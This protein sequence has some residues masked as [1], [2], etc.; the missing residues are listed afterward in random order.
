[1]YYLSLKEVVLMKR[2]V[3]MGIIIIMLLS[4][5]AGITQ[6]QSASNKWGYK[7]NINLQK[8]FQPYVKILTDMMVKNYNQMNQSYQ[9]NYYDVELNG[10]VNMAG[11]MKKDG[12]NVLFDAGDSTNANLSFYFNGTFPYS[13]NVTNFINNNLEPK[14]MNISGKTAIVQTAISNGTAFTDGNGNVSKIISENR[15]FVKMH[16]KGKNLPIPA[17]LYAA[18]KHKYTRTDYVNISWRASFIST[19][20]TPTDLYFSVKLKE[21]I[22]NKEV[23]LI[24]IS[25]VSVEDKNLSVSVEDVNHDGLLDTGDI[26]GIHGNLS[27]M[28]ELMKNYKSIHLQIPFQYEGH[29]IYL[30]PSFFYS[31]GQWMSGSCDIYTILNTIEPHFRKI[32]N[33]F[34]NMS[35]YDNFDFTVEARYNRNTTMSFSPSLSFMPSKRHNLT[36]SVNGDYS[37]TVKIIGLQEKYLKILELLLNKTFTINGNVAEY[38]FSGNFSETK[39]AQAP[40]LHISGEMQYGGENVYV[41]QVINTN[42]T[43]NPSSNYNFH[44]Y[45][46]YSK[47]KRFI[48]GGGIDLGIKKFDTQPTSYEDAMNEIKSI[49]KE[50]ESESNN[51]SAPANTSWILPVSIGIVLIVIITITA[52]AVAKR[53]RKQENMEEENN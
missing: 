30:D 18:L 7:L 11:A 42:D 25:N 31:F 36:M 33:E 32:L 34:S 2:I 35:P 40:T 12:N 19:N 49:Q 28:Q 17:I 24:K 6:G 14:N 47:S 9:I 46:F 5:G 1:M 15:D 50:E 38:S 26:I 44:F 37:G 21:E 39:N 29:T 51:P 45:Y 53:K 20:S 48:V 10:N 16:I 4:V 52:I 27:Y 3:V 43:W 41:V 8:E 13:N 22:D 23:N